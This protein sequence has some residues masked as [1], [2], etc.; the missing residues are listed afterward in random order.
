MGSGELHQISTAIGELRGQMNGIQGWMRRLEQEGNQAAAS[1]Q[2]IKLLLTGLQPA[3]ESMGKRL[4]DVEWAT[5]NLQ[6]ERNQ[7]RAQARMRMPLA[8]GAGGVGGGG[9][10]LALMQIWEAVRPWFAKLGG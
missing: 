9:V 8:A 3:I 4:T 7:E 5:A 1:M 6:R 10:M 2:E